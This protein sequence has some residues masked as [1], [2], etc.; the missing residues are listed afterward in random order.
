MDVP[1]SAWMVNTSAVMPWAAR[2]SAMK[3]LASSAVSVGATI[4]AT[5]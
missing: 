1:R 3:A 5:T 4:Q 2:A